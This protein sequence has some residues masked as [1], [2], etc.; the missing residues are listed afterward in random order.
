MFRDRHRMAAQK[1]SAG[2]ATASDFREIFTEDMSGLHLLALLL[3]ADETLAEQCFVE[4]LEDGI[5]NNSVFRQWARSWARRAIIKNAIKA[6]RPAE[7]EE[8]EPALPCFLTGDAQ[9]DPLVNAVARLAPM[10]R[11]AFAMS[12]LEGYSVAECASLLA[13][14]PQAVIAARTQ[15]M[16]H[17]A[18]SEKSG[19]KNYASACANLMLQPGAA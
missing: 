18:M 13:S 3:T 4:G 2:Y 10:E 11:F 9:K 17:L 19:E 12:V 7:Q 14:S 15:A 16:R 6:V 8:Q 1:Q 5:Q